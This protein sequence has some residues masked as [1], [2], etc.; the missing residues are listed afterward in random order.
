MAA[1]LAGRKCHCPSR[2]C[3]A[4]RGRKLAVHQN[5]DDVVLQ[6][7]IQGYSPAKIERDLNR[8]YKDTLECIVV[9]KAYKDAVMRDSPF[10]YLKAHLKKLKERVSFMQNH[11][12]FWQMREAKCM[13]S[14][15]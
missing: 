11:W 13:I 5:S 8:L 12:H 10:R 14:G 1:A 9:C 4:C 2:F 15:I 3:E 7:L 6:D